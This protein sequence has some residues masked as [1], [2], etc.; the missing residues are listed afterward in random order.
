MFRPVDGVFRPEELRPVE[1]G[2]LKP[3]LFNL[4]EAIGLRPGVPRA[5]E[6]CLWPG[7]SP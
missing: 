3:E 7:F 1:D 6:G 5:V 2:S 4:A